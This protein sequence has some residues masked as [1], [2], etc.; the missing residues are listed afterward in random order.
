MPIINTTPAV[1][2]GIIKEISGT[3]GADQVVKDIQVQGHK[4]IFT[5]G[6][7]G[8]INIINVDGSPLPINQTDKSVSIDLSGKA[9]VSDLTSHTGNGDIHVTT[10]NKS[11]WNAKY[12]KPSGGIPKSDLASA[13]QTSL[14]MADRLVL[15]T[16]IVLAEVDY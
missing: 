8:R 7:S 2:G 12:D 1:V 3:Q 11:A 14:E 16:R 6:D 10:A 5:Y 15:G 4:L 13:V 9:D